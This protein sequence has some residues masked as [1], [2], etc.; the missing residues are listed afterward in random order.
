MSSSHQSQDHIIAKDDTATKP[1]GSGLNGGFRPSHN[2]NGLSNPMVNVQPPRREDLQ[3]SYAQTLAGESDTGAHGWYGSMS[4]LH[5]ELLLRNPAHGS[6]YSQRSRF[7]YRHNGRV[8][9]LYLLSQP[10]QTC[11]A[12]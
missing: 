1:S 2:P 3:P 6:T 4:K 11:F 8:P 12:R 10:I 9:L 7:M 5:L